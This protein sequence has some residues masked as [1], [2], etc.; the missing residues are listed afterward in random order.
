[1]L[2]DTKPSV[3]SWLESV[4]D[5]GA[6]WKY[7]RGMMRPWAVES[8]AMAVDLQ[9][10]VLKQALSTTCRSE[11]A[12]EIQGW[13]DSRKGLFRDALI[14]EKDHVQDAAISGLL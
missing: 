9:V 12:V 3:L 8:S 13:Q 2:S 14:T 1:M 4:H 5:G 7:N 11:W 6:R 10:R